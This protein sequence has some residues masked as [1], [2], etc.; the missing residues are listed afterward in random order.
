MSFEKYLLF[1]KKAVNWMIKHELI[2]GTGLL[3]FLIGIIKL[4]RDK[5]FSQT[6][7]YYGYLKN[8]KR[9]IDNTDL[10][11]WEYNNRIYGK[12]LY[13]SLYVKQINVKAVKSKKEKPSISGLSPKNILILGK[14]GSGKSTYLTYLYKNCISANKTFFNFLF[15]RYYFLVRANLFS[16]NATNDVFEILNKHKSRYITVKYIFID[17]VDEIKIEELSSLVERITS[18]Q[19]KNVSFIV[20]CRKED[21]EVFKKIN[22]TYASL[23]DEIFELKDWEKQQI[24]TYIQNYKKISNNLNYESLM[25]NCINKSVF[26]NFFLNPLE[27]S[28]LSFIIDNN[29]SRE[30][31]INNQYDLYEQFIRHWIIRECLKTDSDID[32]KECVKSSIEILSNLSRRLF[33]EEK[34]ST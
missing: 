15:R 25:N 22:S 17:G 3:T 13:K 6:V 21:H 4:V 19:R 33:K 9:L 26:H 14:P 16:C 32:K 29:R 28:L 11:P 23:F 8:Q 5:I 18:L 1:A 12:D 31:T 2:T 20:T 30:V 7:Q 34:I 10:F 27:L 24:Y